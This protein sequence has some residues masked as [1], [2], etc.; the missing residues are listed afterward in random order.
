[1]TNAVFVL[2]TGY[3][4]G[5]NQPWLKQPTMLWMS[6][7]YIYHYC[8][9]TGGP[10][11]QLFFLLSS[12]KVCRTSIYPALWNGIGEGQYYK[13]NVVSAPNC[14][15][16]THRESHFYCDIDISPSLCYSL[17]PLQCRRRDHR[18]LSCIQGLWKFF[19]LGIAPRECM[20]T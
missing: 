1:M 20:P 11:P 14:F 3:L 16:I 10:V 13:S 6:S 8:L 4:E 19:S 9:K 17:F 18:I 15:D 5:S 7:V 2:N 12:K